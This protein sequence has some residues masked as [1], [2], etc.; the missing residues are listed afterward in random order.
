MNDPK[1]IVLYLSV[2]LLALLTS[3]CLQTQQLY[4][5]NKVTTEQ[6]DLVQNTPVAGTWETFDLKIAY[7][8]VAKD[9]IL[10][11]SGQARLGDHQRMVYDVV[12]TLDIYLFFV[13]HDSRVLLTQPLDRTLTGSTE[14]TAFFSHSYKIPAGTRSL[15]F[16]YSGV[17]TEREGQLSFYQ[18]PLKK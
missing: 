9:D 18:L 3:G 4:I 10:E 11:I 16:G 17:V 12:R 14:R 1:R 15:S 6:V 7:E 5:G 13:D 2:C 8:F